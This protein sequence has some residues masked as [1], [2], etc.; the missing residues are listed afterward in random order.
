MRR[1]VGVTGGI[2]LVRASYDVVCTEATCQTAGLGDFFSR[3]G[4][5]I[6]CQCEVVDLR[7]VGDDAQ[8][9]RRV[10]TSRGQ[11]P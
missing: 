3:I 10:D 7:G 9:E 11:Q 4:R 6:R 5:R 8:K 1:V 2:E